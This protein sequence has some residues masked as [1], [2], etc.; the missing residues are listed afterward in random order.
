MLLEIV[1]EEKQLIESSDEN[2]LENNTSFDNMDPT[3]S[4]C[5]SGQHEHSSFTSVRTS[6]GPVCIQLL[7]QIDSGVCSRDNHRNEK[8]TS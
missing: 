5:K 4:G 1:Y 7:G 2:W 6:F 3:L 8:S